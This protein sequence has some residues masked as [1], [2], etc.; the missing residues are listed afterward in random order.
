M[1]NLVQRKIIALAASASAQTVNHRLLI[2]EGFYSLFKDNLNR[3]HARISQ[4][5]KDNE[6]YALLN[7]ALNQVFA[8]HV[9]GW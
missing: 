7:L 6:L 1:E 2:K 8:L 5:C 4:G 9:V 3:K